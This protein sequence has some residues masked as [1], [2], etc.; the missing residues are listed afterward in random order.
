MRRVA[1][2]VALV[3]ALLAVGGGPA[4]GEATALPGTQIT[5][6]AGALTADGRAQ[7]GAA[8]DELNRENQI[9]LFVVYVDSFDGAAGQDWAAD[10]AER[11]QLGDRDVL[12]AVAVGDRAY[13][14]SVA[15]A[16]PVSDD[17]LGEIEARDVEPAPRGG[18][19]GRRGRG[20]GRWAG[21]GRRLR[22]RRGG[23]YRSECSSAVPRSSEVGRISW[24][25]A[26]A[27][28]APRRPRTR[29]RLRPLLPPP[30]TPTRPRQ[31]QILPTVPAPS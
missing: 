26:G 23:G 10:T 19:L 6:Q 9:Q 20:D 28:R 4:V 21:L 15:Q 7:V 25:G 12:L 17:R 14:T 30:P 27:V 5:D 24:R 16:L 29:S 2:V 22:G 8:L 3:L 31:R 11:S 18:R 1:A 13:G